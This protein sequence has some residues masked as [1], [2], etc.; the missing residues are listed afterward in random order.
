MAAAQ[1]AEHERMAAEGPADGSDQ[2]LEKEYETTDVDP[3]IV[4]RA[5]EG[6]EGDPS[7][8]D[9]EAALRQVD[10]KEDIDKALQ[11][12]KEADAEV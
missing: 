12:K 5:V 9:T 8:G 1:D 2:A 7:E 6:T 10:W 11:A 4:G 3:G